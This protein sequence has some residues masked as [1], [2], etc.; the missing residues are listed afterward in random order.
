MHPL[1]YHPGM[2]LGAMC[3]MAWFARCNGRRL[4]VSA[5]PGTW[6]AQVTAAVLNTATTCISR[7]AWS[8][9]LSDA[10]DDS[11]TSAAF[12]CVI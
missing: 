8:F 2:G 4:D 12:C 7:D 1:E 5:C 11:S 10:A 3:P 9:R 6:G